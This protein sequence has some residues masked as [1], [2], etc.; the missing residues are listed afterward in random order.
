MAGLLA[1]GALLGAALVALLARRRPRPD[2]AHPA[3]SPAER[4]KLVADLR[5]WL[6]RG[7]QEDPS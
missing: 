1:A 3:V 7:S 5:G 6:A 2:S 4:E